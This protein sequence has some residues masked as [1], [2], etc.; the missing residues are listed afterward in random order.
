LMPAFRAKSTTERTFTAADSPSISM[1]CNESHSESVGSKNLVTALKK[2]GRNSGMKE[3]EDE[4][5][6]FAG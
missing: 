6:R 5:P 4:Q 1:D 2:E 3:H